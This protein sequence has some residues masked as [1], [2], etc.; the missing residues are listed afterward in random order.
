M[1]LRI[2]VIHEPK[3][4]EIRSRPRLISSTTGTRDLQQV[5]LTLRI[6]FRP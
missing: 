5:D 3:Y 4:F 1:H 2:P 6:L